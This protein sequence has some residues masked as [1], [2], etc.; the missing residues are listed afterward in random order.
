MKKAIILYSGG[1]DSVLLLLMAVKLG[2]EGQPVMFNYGQAH[3]EELSYAGKLFAKLRLGPSLAPPITLDLRGAFAHTV[4]SLL[5]PVLGPPFPGVHAMHCPGRNG[6]FLFTGIGLAEST[7]AEEVWIGCDYS[8]RINRF[9]DCYQEWIV[10]MDEIAQI[11]ASRPIRV[12]APLLGLTKEDVVG[13]LKAEGVELAEIYSGYSP[14]QP[15]VP[16]ASQTIEPPR[17]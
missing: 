3:S 7:G 15:R 11:S 12:K 10:K 1:A 8:D 13:L 6:I 5:G 9:P 17:P 2:Y 14:P 16:Q 4:S